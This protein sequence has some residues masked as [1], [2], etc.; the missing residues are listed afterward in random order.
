MCTVRLARR[1]VSTSDCLELFLRRLKEVR[2][3][4]RGCTVTWQG[5]SIKIMGKVM[6][7][8]WPARRASGGANYGAAEAKTVS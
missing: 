6:Q 7:L 2:V 1:A 8:G 3:V 4:D 5:G